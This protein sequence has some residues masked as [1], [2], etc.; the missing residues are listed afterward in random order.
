[1]VLLVKEVQALIHAIDSYIKM[2]SFATTVNI[3]WL[4]MK[5]EG[6]NRK[7][8]ET[9]LPSYESFGWASK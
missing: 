2:A 4:S 7:F 1:M 8:R 9:S 3:A 5:V 6:L